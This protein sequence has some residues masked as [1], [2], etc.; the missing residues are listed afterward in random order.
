MGLLTTL[1]VHGKDR[2]LIAD[3]TRNRALWCL[4]A[5]LRGMIVK[6]QGAQFA[7]PRRNEQSDRER[8][9]LKQ[10][11]YLKN[12]VTIILCKFNIFHLG[13]FPFFFLLLLL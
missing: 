12:R 11:I 4:E 1:N 10:N 3:G 13:V 5:D 7:D 9:D 8:Y 6:L 2:T